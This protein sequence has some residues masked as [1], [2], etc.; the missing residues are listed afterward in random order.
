MVS[1]ERALESIYRV[2]NT[3]GIFIAP[4]YCHGS[5]VLSRTISSIMSLIGFKAYH[6]WS[7]DGFRSF[8]ESHFFEVVRFQVIKGG[9]PLVCAI[10]K[11]KPRVPH[12]AD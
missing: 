10:S 1:P 9:V 12:A 6:K 5:S 4:T 3:N 11:K 2:L 8:L 7:P